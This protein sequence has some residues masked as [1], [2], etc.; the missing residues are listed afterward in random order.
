[1]CPEFKSGKLSACSRHEVAKHHSVLGGP[2]TGRVQATELP[3]TFF[4]RLQCIFYNVIFSTQTN[5]IAE[6][7]KQ[8]IVWSL[9]R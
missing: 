1:M 3:I 2:G 5:V 7:L 9:V 8:G 6:I 4:V